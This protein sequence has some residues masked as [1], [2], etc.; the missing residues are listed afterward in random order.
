MV[1]KLDMSKAYDRCITRVSY[2]VIINGNRGSSFQPSRGLRQGDPLSP[3]LFLICSEGLSALMRMAKQNGLVKGTRASRSGPAISHL[4]FADDCILFGEAP[5]RGARVLKGILQ[6]YAYC[7]GQC[8]NF[9]KSTVFFSANMA[10]ESK[11]AVSSFLGVQSSESSE[12]YL[13]LP[14]MV[15][16]RKK[17]A[18]QNLVDRIAVRIEA[19]S[20]RLLSQGGKEIFIKSVLQ[21]IPTYAM[22]CFLFPKALCEMIES[23][24]AHF[25]WQ[26]GAGKRAIH[27]CQ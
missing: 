3:F 10:E 15:S 4:L 22:S 19:W 9:D 12:R 17:E 5:E 26:K 2:A 13:G 25:W 21:A 18:F 6:E 16:R 24:I 8:V 14:N 1:V 27:W 7:S 11:V 20:S 23:R